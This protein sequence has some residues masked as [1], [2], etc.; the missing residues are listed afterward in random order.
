MRLAIIPQNNAKGMVIN[1]GNLKI[2]T[3]SKI[4]AKFKSKV[5]RGISKIFENIDIK[6]NFLNSQILIGNVKIETAILTDIMVIKYF[7]T[8]F[9]LF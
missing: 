1:M 9:S 4:V 7:K 3:A 6:D 8:L 5:E 2:V